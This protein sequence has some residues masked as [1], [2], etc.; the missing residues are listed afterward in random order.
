MPGDLRPLPDPDVPFSAWVGPRAAAA[1]HCPLVAP[2]LPG[3]ETS[4]DALDAWEA[5]SRLLE[6]LGH[7]VVDVD[8]PFPA[9]LEPQFNVVWSSGMAAAPVP[10]EAITRCGPTPATGGLAGASR[11]RWS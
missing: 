3:I 4:H 7:E 1:A 9:E 8:N 6:S 11:R 5:A 10:E 2:H